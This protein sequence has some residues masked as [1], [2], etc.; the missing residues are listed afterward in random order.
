MRCTHLGGEREGKEGRTRI[1]M[2][3]LSPTPVTDTTQSSLDPLPHMG[4]E[5]P[6]F[7]VVHWFVL[8]AAHTWG[9]GNGDPR[10]VVL[11]PLLM[12]GRGVESGVWIWPKLVTTYNLPPNC[13]ILE[14]MN[15][16]CHCQKVSKGGHMIARAYQKNYVHQV[17][18]MK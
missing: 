8:Q 16:L 1:C 17:E 10:A 15:V 13:T 3:Y 5:I 11:V 9:W 12:A 7:L 6:P 14:D 4:E 2:T 18:K